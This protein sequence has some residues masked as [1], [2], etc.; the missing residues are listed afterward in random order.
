MCTL[1]SI[2]LKFYIRS[3]RTAQ[4]RVKQGKDAGTVTETPTTLWK[5]STKVAI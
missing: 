3:T 4:Y 2:A 5:E 1:C